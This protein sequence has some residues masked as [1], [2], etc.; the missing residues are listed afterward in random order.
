MT[1]SHQPPATSHSPGEPIGLVAGSGRF[2][3][4]FAEAAR[5][6]GLRVVAIGHRGDTDPSLANSVDRFHWVHLG[7]VGKMT[8]LFRGESVS[9]AVMAGGIGKL[10]ALVRARPDW[11]GLA[12]AAK[13][14]NLN[15]DHVL[16]TLADVFEQAGV[17]IEPS[18]VF[19]PELLAPAGVLSQRQP[20]ESEQQ[21]IAF[22][23]EVA[24]AVGKADVGQTVVV[25]AR[26]VLA[27][28]ASEG[29]DPTITRG[30]DY[31]QGRAVV[32]K[33]SKP[34]QD[35]RFDLP[36]IGERTIAVMAAHGCKA[37]AVEAGRT[38]LLD[39]QAVLR[40]A[41]AAGIVVVGIAP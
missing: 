31:G 7:Q 40:A 25:E 4:L 11:G 12:F 2:P 19:T 13:L 18:T 20:S 16:R 10:S 6:R 29:T 9:R 14:R 21:D 33:I 35:L 22:G 1:A 15:D 36:A 5:A 26:Q 28:E 32:V 41:D 8:R 34:G 37:L 30:G 23:L 38:L 24:R 17:R 3:V 39:G 27:V